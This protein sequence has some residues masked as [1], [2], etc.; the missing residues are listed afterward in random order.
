VEDMIVCIG[1]DMADVGM[2]NVVLDCGN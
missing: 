1:K 2:D